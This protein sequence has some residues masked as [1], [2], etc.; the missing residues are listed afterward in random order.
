MLDS[1]LVNKYFYVA[2][3]LQAA[4][5]TANSKSALKYWNIWFITMDINV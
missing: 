5:M 2:L 4:L 1:V 3:E